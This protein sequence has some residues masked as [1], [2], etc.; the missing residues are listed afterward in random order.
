MTAVQDSKAMCRI[1]PAL[2]SQDSKG[3]IKT[4]Q[5]LVVENGSYADVITKHG[6]L[7]GKI[8]ETS[9][10]ITKGKNIG[11]SNETTAWEQAVSEAQSAWT[12]KNDSGYIEDL[13]A[14]Q[15]G[16]KPRLPMLALEYE[17][18]KH[19]VTF[20]CYTQP[21]LEGVR[22][23]ATR[24]GDEIVY[25][26]RNG[27]PFTTLDHLTPELLVV[28]EDG[29]TIDGELFNKQY[30]FQSIV[31]A[32]KNNSDKSNAGILQYHVYD[33]PSC[34]G[35]FGQRIASLNR[36]LGNIQ[37]MYVKKVATIMADSEQTIEKQHAENNANHYE[38]TM[39]RN[40]SGDYRYNYRS[41]DLLKMKDFVD[42]E[43]KIVDVEEGVGKDAGKAT[44]VCESEDGIRFNARPRG[45]DEVRQEY[46]NNR[47]KYI[48]KLLTVRYQRL[49]D[50]GRPYLPVGITIRDYE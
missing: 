40:E 11:R 13:E 32:I 15:N 25:S 43:Y 19:D 48:G 1:L 33:F 24:K 2:Y 47:T 30:T 3:R 9:K 46:W 45:A 37:Q 28:L 4:W 50:D 31:S 23:F 8:Q 12:R 29:E 42:D 20:P 21:K 16:E 38:G 49:T 36:R 5:T 18:R 26:S 39:I 34:A 35:G 22:C 10:T 6:L 14:A 41:P 44:F 17:K 27:K 7:G